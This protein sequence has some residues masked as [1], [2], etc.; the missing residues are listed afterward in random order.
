MRVETQ[1]NTTFK[2]NNKKAPEKE[3]FF[4]AIKVLL[5]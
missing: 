5:K 2:F 4:Y 3:A 1:R